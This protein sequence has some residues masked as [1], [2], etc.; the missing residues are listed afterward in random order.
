MKRL[1]LALRAAATLL[2]PALLTPPAAAQGPWYT[3]DEDGHGIILARALAEGAAARVTTVGY[4]Y[5][6]AALRGAARPDPERHRLIRTVWR[7][8]CAN[9][10]VDIESRTVQ[11]RPLGPVRPV[12]PRAP[13]AHAAAVRAHACDGP[14]GASWRDPD[15]ARLA[16]W[17][18]LMAAAYPWM[19]EQAPTPARHE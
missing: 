13:A 4:A 12:G 3:L 18:A 17:R 2:L 5:D 15:E 19:T 16:K 14:Q 11:Q 1:R 10:R 6:P 8:D 9:A 7:V